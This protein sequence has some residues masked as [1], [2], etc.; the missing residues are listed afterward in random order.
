MM[1]SAN[2]PTQFA[3]DTTAPC[4]DVATTLTWGSDWSSVASS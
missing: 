3:K 2:S 1:D 4:A